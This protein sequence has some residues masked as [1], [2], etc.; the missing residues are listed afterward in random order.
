MPF[1]AAKGTKKNSNCLITINREYSS[2]RTELQIILSCCILFLCFFLVLQCILS[3]LVI[4]FSFCVGTDDDH[5]IDA[6]NM[7]PFIVFPTSVS[8]C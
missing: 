5:F 4:C 6:N 1:Y 2:I 7:V 3:K 8:F